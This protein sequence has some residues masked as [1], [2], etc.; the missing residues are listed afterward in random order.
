MNA[1]IVTIWARYE[2]SHRTSRMSATTDAPSCRAL[3]ALVQGL[4]RHRREQFIR[5]HFKRPCKAVENGRRRLQ[6]ALERGHLLL[7]S[8]NTAT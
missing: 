6:P 8:A 5:V 2:R 4:Q 7:S 3:V 1:D